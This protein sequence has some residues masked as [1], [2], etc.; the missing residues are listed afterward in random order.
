MFSFKRN[1]FSILVATTVMDVGI[2]APDT[3]ITIIENVEQF[4]YRSYSS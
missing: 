3:I 4:G 1:E 2:D